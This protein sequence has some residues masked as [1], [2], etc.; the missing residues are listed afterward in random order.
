MLLKLFEFLKQFMIVTFSIKLTQFEETE[1]I[2]IFLLRKLKFNS[3]FEKKEVNHV[4]R[5]LYKF[6][7]R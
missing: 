6:A 3:T 4:F 1:S 7:I 2:G 5:D